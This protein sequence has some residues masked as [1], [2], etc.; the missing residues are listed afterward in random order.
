MWLKCSFVTYV[1]H[2][3]DLLGYLHKQTLSAPIQ[4][5]EHVFFPAWEKYY[6]DDCGGVVS[7]L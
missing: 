6:R 7:N 3:V 2:S 5:L 1:D 4:D